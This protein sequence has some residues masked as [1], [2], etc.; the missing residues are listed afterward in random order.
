MSLNINIS[1]INKIYKNDDNKEVIISWQ[2]TYWCNYKCEYC[3]QRRTKNVDRT[4]PNMPFLCEQASKINNAIEASDVTNFKLSL[5][6]GEI[7]YIDLKY[8]FDNYLTSSKISRVHITTNLSRDIDYFIDIKNYFNQKNIKVKISPS[9][10]LTQIKNLDDFINKAK[11][12]KSRVELVVSEYNLHL[13]ENAI[14]KLLDANLSPYLE[15]D[16]MSTNP[17]YIEEVTN[18]LILKYNLEQEDKKK[19]YIIEL[20]NKDKLEVDKNDITRYLCDKSFYNSNIICSTNIRFS[21]NKWLKGT[22]KQRSILAEEEDLK[23][24]IHKSRCSDCSKACSFCGVERME[25][26]LCD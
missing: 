4:F 12:L 24:F 23:S 1:D 17:K 8:L 14:V 26:E 19:S 7:T 22:C 11:Y 18:N 16:R 21:N 25:F 5:I 3:I 20:K 2:M 15:I 6:G 10:H 9:L 13:L